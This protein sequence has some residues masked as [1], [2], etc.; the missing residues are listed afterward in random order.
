MI[1]VVDPFEFLGLSRR[2]LLSEEEIGEAYRT[3]AASLHPDQTGGDD[4]R[5]K[6]L[7]E[8][9]AVLRDPSRRIRLLCG[10]LP[11]SIPPAEAADLF[12]SVAML[13]R[14]AADLLARHTAASS[15]LAKAVLA[16]PLA[17]LSADLDLLLGK[18]AEWRSRLDVALKTLD[19]SWPDH[20]P[21][22]MATLADSFSYAARW[23]SQLR[24]KRLALECL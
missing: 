14:E 22:A 23:E 10:V 19:A 2:P 18:I 15:P 8:A 4:L 12:P 1:P 17:K 5:F 20:E 21:T 11:G 3:L 9:V 16:A 24:E 13:T 7:G 6:E